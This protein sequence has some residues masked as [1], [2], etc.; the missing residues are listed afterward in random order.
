MTSQKYNDE[1]IDTLLNQ[2]SPL[3]LLYTSNDIDLLKSL[4]NGEY[5]DKEEYFNYIIKVKYPEVVEYILSKRY[6]VFTNTNFVIFLQK[7]PSK[8]LEKLKIILL[9]SDEL[10]HNLICTVGYK[11]ISSLESWHEAMSMANI[12]YYKIIDEIIKNIY[13]GE[14]KYE[15]L[16]ALLQIKDVY[17]EYVI[18]TT[19]KRL[20]HLTAQ[21][22]RFMRPQVQ[23]DNTFRNKIERLKKINDMVNMGLLD[24]QILK[25]MVLIYDDKDVKEFLELKKIKL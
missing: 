2:I 16:A 8:L 15:F 5:I 13:D 17:F 18:D 12:D 9:Y 22:S 20:L 21:D 14:N 3:D 11:Y 19:D 6:V 7:K 25:N 4:I 10:D 23:V 1:Y 24:V